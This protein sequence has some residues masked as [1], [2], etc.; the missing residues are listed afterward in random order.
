MKTNKILIAVLAAILPAV[1]FADTC[2]TSLMPT[3]TSAQASAICT[4]AS[5]SAINHSMI[6]STTNTYALGSSSKLWSNI[7]STSLTL[8]TA[9]TGLVVGEASRASNVTTSTGNFPAAYLSVDGSAVSGGALVERVQIQTHSSL[10]SLRLVQ[11][12]D[13]RQL[14]YRAEIL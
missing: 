14:S 11:Q 6:P 7:Y 1:S 10:I 3:F 5:G 8:P 13:R 12:V 4:K 2:S 9:A